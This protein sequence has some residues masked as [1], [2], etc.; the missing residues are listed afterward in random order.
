MENIWAKE[1][2]SMSKSNHWKMSKMVK[3]LTSI[4]Q[5]WM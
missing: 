2:I 5:D 4:S 3:D 1:Q